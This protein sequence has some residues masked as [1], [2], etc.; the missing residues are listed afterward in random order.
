MD[1]INKG[2]QTQSWAFRKWAGA[3]LS[4]SRLIPRH[5][6]NANFGRLFAPMRHGKIKMIQV[7]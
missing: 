3:R 4:Q 5:F 1:I 7:R 2:R 6:E